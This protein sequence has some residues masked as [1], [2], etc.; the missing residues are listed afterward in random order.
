MP[1]AQSPHALLPAW[2]VA[3]EK[4]GPMVLDGQTCRVTHH[5][6]ELILER[7]SIVLAEPGTTLSQAEAIALEQIIQLRQQ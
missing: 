2:F 7:I 5:E 6:A 1:T 4:T 3:K